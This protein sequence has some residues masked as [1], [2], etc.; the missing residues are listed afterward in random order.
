[1]NNSTQHTLNISLLDVTYC[2]ETCKFPRYLLARLLSK[3]QDEGGAR[4]KKG[5]LRISG[6]LGVFLLEA[7]LKSIP[8]PS[9]SYS[10]IIYFPKD[11]SSKEYLRERYWV[12]CNFLIDD[13]KWHIRFVYRK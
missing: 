8:S 3:A 11:E 1:M 6:V 13:V 7:H 4:G 9:W 2:R 10:E 5:V 12:Q